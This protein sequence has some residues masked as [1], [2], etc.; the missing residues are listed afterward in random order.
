ME[1]LNPPKERGILGVKLLAK[2]FSCFL[3][4]KKMICDSPLGGSIGQQF[5][6]LP[7]DFGVCCVLYKTAT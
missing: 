3:H 1:V 5:R 6:L 7:N 4:T 2:T